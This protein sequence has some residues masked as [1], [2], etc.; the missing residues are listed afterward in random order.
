[1]SSHAYPMQPFL[2]AAEPFVF[3]HVADALFPPPPP[4][5]PPR[6]G[7]RRV[8]APGRHR[9]G[10]RIER[11]GAMR[12]ADLQEYVLVRGGWDEDVAGGG[13]G[14]GE[15]GGGDTQGLGDT[16]GKAVAVDRLSHRDTCRGRILSGR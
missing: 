2:A 14:E 6:Q 9:G 15:G 10:W 3:F 13:E 5:P 4:P 1:M 7:R 11:D 16:N 8:V 12:D